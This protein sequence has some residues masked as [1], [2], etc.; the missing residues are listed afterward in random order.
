MD[1]NCAL[2]HK[3]AKRKLGQYPTILT[4]HWVS[5]IYFSIFLITNDIEVETKY[6]GTLCDAYIDWHVSNFLQS[7]TCL[8]Y[9]QKLSCLFFEEGNSLFMQQ[10]LFLQQR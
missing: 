3:N 1:I 10:F 8:F 2:F 9:N 4:L 5:N 7:W 6:E